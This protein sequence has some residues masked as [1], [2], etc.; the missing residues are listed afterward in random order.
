M[1]DRYG[2]HP[3]SA[4][5]YGYAPQY[6]QY[7]QGHGYGY[8]YGQRVRLSA[9]ASVHVIA[10]LQYL[11]GLLGLLV[12]AAVAVSALA[13]RHYLDE[14]GLPADV[15]DAFAGGGIV[16]AGVI[17][18]V[19]LFAMVLGRRLQRGRNWA[20]VLLLL[21]STLNL[22]TTLYAVFAQD[23]GSGGLVGIVVPVLYLVLLNTRAARS[24]FHHG[25]Y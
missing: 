6:D 7:G 2:Y 1:S 17:G 12:A 13:G 21:L 11:G 19:A 5:G 4:P 3:G 23:L 8:G 22:A 24:W 10:I 15:R 9:P 18:F 16:V 20:R 25:T 14:Q